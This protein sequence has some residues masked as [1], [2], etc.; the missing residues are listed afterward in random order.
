MRDKLPV[1]VQIARAINLIMIVIS[2]IVGILLAM[3]A[4]PNFIKG[5][6]S[7]GKEANPV[8]LILV[9][10]TAFLIGAIPAILLLI[11]NR[12]LRKLKPSARAWQIVV[13]CIVLLWFPVGTMLSIIVLYFMLFDKST[14]D[15]FVR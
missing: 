8:L 2:G 3:I 11:L 9:G 7:A 12:N 15:A 14:K 13:S 4:T 6:Q 5:A 1:G 10:L